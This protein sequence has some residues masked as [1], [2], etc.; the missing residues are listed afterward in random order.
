MPKGLKPV[1]KR[2]A[3]GSVRTYWYH[4]ATGKR[5]QADPTTAEGFLEVARLDDV[6]GTIQAATAALSGSYGELWAKYRDSPKWRSLKP[7]TRSDYQAVRDWLGPAADVPLRSIKTGDLER[8]RDRAFEEKGRRFA[9]YVIQVLRLTMTWGIKRDHCKE[10]LAAGM[11]MIPKPKGER[12]VNRA[13]S[14]EEVTAFLDGAPFQLTVPFAMALL[15]GMRQGDALKVTWS[16]Y[17]GS[18]LHWTAGKNGEV[19]SAP[20]GSVLKSVLEL[21]KAS[22]GDAVQ[23]AVNSS[24]APWSGSGFRASFFK[25]L[26]DLR[27]AGLVQPGCTFHGLRHTVGAIGRDGGH[28]EWAIA[29]AIGDRS[30]TMASVYGRDADSQIGRE[31]VL[32]D[33]EK[34]FANIDWKPRTPVSNRARLE[35]AK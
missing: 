12:K 16:G 19:V 27:I 1:R 22:R 23:I 29:S 20:V 10:N 9:N 18:S 13:W 34:R 21:A 15:A 24:G 33:V 25:R 6:A 4:R 31:G 7:R 30:T 2:L 14:L 26:R 5:I 3:D 11:G 17:D 28:S 8:L 32:K 35:P